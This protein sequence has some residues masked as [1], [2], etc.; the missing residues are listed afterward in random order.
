MDMRRGLLRGILGAVLGFL[1]AG[2]WY[3]GAVFFGYQGSVADFQLSIII[4]GTALAVI[5]GFV[6]WYTG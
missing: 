1:L 3:L 5:L 4:V 6:F 2:V